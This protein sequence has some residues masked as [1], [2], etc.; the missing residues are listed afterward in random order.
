M[1]R[2]SR[3]SGSAAC[4]LAL[5]VSTLAWAGAQRYTNPQ[6]AELTKD[7]KTLA[8]LPFKVAIDT[9]NLSKNTTMEMIQSA[10]KDEAM[11]FQRQLYARFLQKTQEEQYRVA[12]Q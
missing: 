2:L 12:F 7:H 9:K 8:I 5:L 4:L 6:F 3:P 1:L 11:E 10:E